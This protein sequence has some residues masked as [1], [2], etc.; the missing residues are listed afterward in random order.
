MTLAIVNNE[1]SNK[2][3]ETYSFKF[4][5]SSS[6]VELDSLNVESSE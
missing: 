6:G 3:I 5:Y 1:S 2:A 4:S